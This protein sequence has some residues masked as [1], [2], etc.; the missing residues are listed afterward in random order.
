MVLFLF[1]HS[2]FL[3]LPLWLFSPLSGC[4]T[5]AFLFVLTHSLLYSFFL[6]SQ[7]SLPFS[8]LPYHAVLCCLTLWHSLSISHSSFL[9]SAFTVSY[10]HFLTLTYSHLPSLFLSLP[11]RLLAHIFYLFPLSL[12]FLLSF[13]LIY[14]ITLL[15][16]LSP[17]LGLI[18]PSPLLSLLFVPTLALSLFLHCPLT[19]A[20]TL[21]LALT[22]TLSFLLS[23]VLAFSLVLF[24]SLLFLVYSDSAVSLILPCFSSPWLA[25]SLSHTP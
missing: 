24:L 20:P 13:A 9:S 3:A 6:L 2:T 15:F 23:L 19:L 14:R 10:Y 22:C 12:S 21:P 1:S 16:T 25:L 7:C 5:L 18:H 11:A 4:F 8:L 17:L